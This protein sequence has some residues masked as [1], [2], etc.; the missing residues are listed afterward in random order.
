MCH[1]DDG[2]LKAGQKADHLNCTGIVAH[3]AVELQESVLETL[4]NVDKLFR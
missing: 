4:E 2:F 1:I 3:S